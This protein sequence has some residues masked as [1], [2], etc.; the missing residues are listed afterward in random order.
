M[1]PRPSLEPNAGADGAPS[2]S[3][4]LDRVTTVGLILEVAAGLRRTINPIIE[5]ELGV[6]SGDLEALI[7]LVRSPGERLR[8]SDLAAQTALTPSGLTRAVDRLAELRLVRRQGC[9]DDR[10][11][12][13]AVMTPR[14]KQQMER[15]MRIHRHQLDDLFGNLLEPGEE[16]M[17]VNVLRRLRD[18][19]NPDAARL[20]D[21]AEGGVSEC[22]DQRGE[23]DA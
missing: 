14:G 11:G 18:R 9:P 12:A 4:S 3:E 2:P 20:S 5:A 6:G 23:D 19:V 17:V 10:R 16:E 22:E 15:V 13:F 21:S 1:Q 7:R 8:L